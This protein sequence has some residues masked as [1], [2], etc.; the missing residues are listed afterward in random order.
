M[1]FIFTP[2]TTNNYSMK[3]VILTFSVLGLLVIASC[4]TE[5]DPTPSQPSLR[6]GSGGD[7]TPRIGGNSLVDPTERRGGDSLG[8]KGGNTNVVPMDRSGKGGDSLG[9][10]GGSILKNPNT[11]RRGGDSIG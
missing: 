11:Y 5:G 7:S 10:Q 4:S 2:S 9:R 3:K 8:R 1:L 6:K